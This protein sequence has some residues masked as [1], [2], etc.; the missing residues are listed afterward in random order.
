[1]RI[2]PMLHCTVQDLGVIVLESSN[3]MALNFLYVTDLRMPGLFV[4]NTLQARTFKHLEDIVISETLVG[5][6]GDIYDKT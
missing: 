5:A 1:M 2:T 4:W 6:I 3:D